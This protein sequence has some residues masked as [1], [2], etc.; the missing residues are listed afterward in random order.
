MKGE[1]SEQGGAAVPASLGGR[2]TAESQPM[3]I[4]SHGFREGGERGITR[5]GE[6]DVETVSNNGGMIPEAVDVA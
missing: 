4:P 1:N 3:H 2:S 5:I 6:A